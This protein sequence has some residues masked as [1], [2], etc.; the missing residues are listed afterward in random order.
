MSEC[1]FCSGVLIK[2]EY[3]GKGFKT[4]R[5]MLG[6]LCG[7]DEDEQEICENGIQLQEG[8]RLAFDNSA[9]EYALLSIEIKYC[10]F[11]GESL[12]AE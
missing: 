2:A 10:P 7:S 1:A 4:M 8:N 9:G 3:C 6:M 5:M 12:V 11:C